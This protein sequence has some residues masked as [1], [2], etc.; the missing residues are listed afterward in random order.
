MA[1][2]VGLEVEVNWIE[3]TFEGRFQMMS[4]EVLNF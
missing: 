1:S 4:F 2:N 3:W